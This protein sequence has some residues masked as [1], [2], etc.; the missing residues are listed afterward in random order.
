MKK[1][2]F[3]S[4]PLGEDVLRQLIKVVNQI[5]IN[6]VRWIPSENWHITLLFMGNVQDNLIS[7]IIEESESVFKGISPFNLKFNKIVFVPENNARMI[8]AQY[9]NS[10]SYDFLSKSICKKLKRFIVED[11]NDHSRD[12]IPH[13]TLARFNNSAY[14]V[15]PRLPEIQICNLQVDTVNLMESQLTVQGSIY[16][17]LYEFKI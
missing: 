5:K 11:V 4:I 9:E 14:Q 6:N 13:I 8:W 10:D 7:E 16:T 3:F 12:V 17:K 15:L 1:R 2:L